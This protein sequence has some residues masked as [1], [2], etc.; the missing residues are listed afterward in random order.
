MSP[1]DPFSLDRLRDIVVP[2]PVSWWPPAPAWYY[3]LAVVCLWTIVGLVRAILRWN[4]NAYRREALRELAEVPRGDFLGLSTLLKRV[5]LVAYPRDRVASLI[6]DDWTNFLTA[7]SRGADF[8]SKPA[9]RIGTAAYEN[10]VHEKPAECDVNQ[11]AGVIDGAR[12]WIRRHEA[13]PS[14]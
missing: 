10:P 4:R 3:V 14:R 8:G 11:W 12:R 1:T 9:R 5:A 6:G 2:Q 13:E 7:T